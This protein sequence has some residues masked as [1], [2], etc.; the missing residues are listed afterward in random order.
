MTKSATIEVTLKNKLG[1]HARP[2]AILVKT[3]SK[4][5]SEISIK[6]DEEEVNGKSLIGLLMLA[7]E[8][9]SILK[10]SAVGADAYQALE[11]LEN[12]IK[13]DKEFLEE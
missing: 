6:K 11:S 12:L 7:A 2:A 4:F 10:I 5:E 8:Y 13:N 9:N 1:L 3:S